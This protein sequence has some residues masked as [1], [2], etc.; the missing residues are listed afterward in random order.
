VPWYGVVV[1][2][3]RELPQPRGRLELKCHLLALA[4]LQ[5]LQRL[6]EGA[7]RRVEIRYDARSG[8]E[9]SNDSR[10]A[11]MGPPLGRL[12]TRTRIARS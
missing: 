1:D 3:A 2:G 7:Y 12:T 9:T 5:V 4:A 10:L 11:R 6:T 8:D